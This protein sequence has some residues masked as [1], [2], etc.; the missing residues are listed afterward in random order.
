MS[1]QGQGGVHS[2]NELFKDTLMQTVP[3]KMRRGGL[4]PGAVIALNTN[5]YEL[6]IFNGDSGFVFQNK[7]GDF[8]LA[9][10]GNRNSATVGAFSLINTNQL[11]RYEFAYAMTVHK[12]Q[13]SEFDNVLLS[14]PQKLNSNLVNRQLLYTAVTR[15]KNSICIL[16]SQEIIDDCINNARTDSMQLQLS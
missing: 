2:I 14:C 12:S 11:A 6:N 10:E 1:K 9:L 3:K 15:A 4:F 16:S 7:K 5:N 8:Y 13:G